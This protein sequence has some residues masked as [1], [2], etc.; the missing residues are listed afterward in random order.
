MYIYKIEIY[1]N[2]SFCTPRVGTINYG[3]Y[4]LSPCLAVQASTH[5][6]KLTLYAEKCDKICTQV[7]PTKVPEETLF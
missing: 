1:C 6:C 3:N 4:S 7:S 5:S 2:C